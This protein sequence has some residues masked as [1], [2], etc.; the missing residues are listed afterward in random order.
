[1]ATRRYIM[2]LS[3]TLWMF[4]YIANVMAMQTSETEWESKMGK[5]AKEYWRKGNNEFD[6]LSVLKSYIYLNLSV[7][8]RN[9]MPRLIRSLRPPA[10]FAT[11]TRVMVEARNVPQTS[12]QNRWPCSCLHGGFRAKL[13]MWATI[14]G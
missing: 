1:V 12:Y 5:N 7:S 3:P 4:T 13:N 2:Q 6:C 14:S 8:M 10:C 9:K 11:I